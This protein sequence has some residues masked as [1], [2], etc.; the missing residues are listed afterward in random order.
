MSGWYSEGLEGLLAR[1]IPQAATVEAMGVNTQYVYNSEHSVGQINPDYIILEGTPLSGVTFTGGYLD[2]DNLTWYAA[3][4]PEDE[5]I[6]P[7]VKAAV[8][9]FKDGVDITLLA[10]MDDREVGVPSTLAG[11]NFIASWSTQGLLKI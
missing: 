3:Q 10:Y 4:A 1:T 6:S 11:A 9:Y 5:T 2:A 7:I 8:I